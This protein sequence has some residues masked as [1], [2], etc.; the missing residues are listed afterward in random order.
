MTTPNYKRICAIYYGAVIN[1]DF[2]KVILENNL[3]NSK[4]IEYIKKYT[5]NERK[6][7]FL[8][9]RIVKGVT[10]ENL[11]YSYP[12]WVGLYFKKMKRIERDFE[13]WLE[14]AVKL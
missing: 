3:S 4:I 9:D 1:G 11:C 14:K 8:K 10:Y 6:R 5:K 12:E 2:M 13:K 7:S